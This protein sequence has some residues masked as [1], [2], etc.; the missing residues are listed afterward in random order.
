MALTV[1]EAG[2]STCQTL[3][4]LYHQ[5]C[6]FSADLVQLIDGMLT[7]DATA[8]ATLEAVTASE[9]L[10][11]A[12]AVARAHGELHLLAPGRLYALRRW[13]PVRR[14]VVI[15]AIY[16]YWMELTEHLDAPGGA[17]ALADMEEAMA[18]YG[19]G[20][21]LMEMGGGDADDDDIYRG[22][23]FDAAFSYRS[24]AAALPSEL[25]D[26]EALVAS[27]L[28]QLG[29][30]ETPCKLPALVRQRAHADTTPPVE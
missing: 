3:F 16:N 14:A 23:L 10:S 29:A 11:P 5:Q 18:V 6:H 19:P 12:S 27:V 22:G 21:A 8:R 13:Q 2:G 9:W 17:R 20:G 7:I 26:V 24:L 4:G 15:R 28:G 30:N 25:F 1:Q